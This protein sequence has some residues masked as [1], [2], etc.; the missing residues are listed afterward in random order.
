MDIWYSLVFFGKV[1]F[2]IIVGI[3]L[4]LIIERWVQTY[5]D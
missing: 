2:V 3:F 1:L 4:V 5:K